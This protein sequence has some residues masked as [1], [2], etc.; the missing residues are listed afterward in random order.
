MVA[1]NRRRAGSRRYAQRSV[2]LDL[3]VAKQVFFFHGFQN[4]ISSKKMTTKSDFQNFQKTGIYVVE[5]AV[6]NQCAKFQLDTIIFDPQKGCF[7]VPIVPNDD[8]IPSNAFFIVLALVQKKTNGTIGLQRRFCIRN[9][10]L[11][12]F[13]FWEFDLFWKFWPDHELNFAFFGSNEVKL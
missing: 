6:F 7:C 3:S 9:M 11:F 1:R 5:I 12:S 13:L 4:H 10:S 8:V 2:S